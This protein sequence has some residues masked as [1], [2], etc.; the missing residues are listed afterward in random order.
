VLLHLE[1]VRVVAM[2]QVQLLNQEE[3]VVA[4]VEEIHQVAQA[5]LALAVQVAL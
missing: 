5:Q 3:A 1:V 4:V 2:V